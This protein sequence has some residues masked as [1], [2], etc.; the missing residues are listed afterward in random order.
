MSAI[1]KT[2][3]RALRPLR[4]REFELLTSFIRSESGISLSSAKKALVEG[5]LKRRL[6]NLGL[7]SYYDYYLLLGRDDGSERQQ[8]LNLITTNET[9]FFREPAHFELIEK[10]LVP[11]WKRAAEDGR[12]DRHI[13]VWSAGCSTG[14]EPYS[15]AMC[16]HRALPEIE[17][18]T[19]DIVASDISTKAL[20]HAVRGI[21]PIDRAS[22]IPV[23]HRDRFVLRGRGSQSGMIKIRRDLRDRIRFGRF[24]LNRRRYAFSESFDLILCRNVLIYFGRDERMAVVNRFLD[25]LVDD[26]VLMLGH[27]ESLQGESDRVRCVFPTVYSLT[28]G[29]SKDA[30]LDRDEEGR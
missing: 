30:A 13:R 5:R 25:L 18:W 21:Y 8:M 26:G 3:R 4:D 14:E 27:A 16:L 19:F 9:S 1:E 17:G 23:S 15:I 11:K 7:Q 22:S 29:R 28:G 20:E 6:Q 12:I 2:S 24:N 10:T